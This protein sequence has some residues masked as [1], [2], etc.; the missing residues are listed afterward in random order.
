MPQLW[1]QQNYQDGKVTSVPAAGRQA[2][3]TAAAAC[4]LSLGKRMSYHLDTYIWVYRLP[5]VATPYNHVYVVTLSG[6]Q[7]LFDLGWKLSSYT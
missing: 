1:S 6:H 4:F 7:C 2:C 3:F 5:C